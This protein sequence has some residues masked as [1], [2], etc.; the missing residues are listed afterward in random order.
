MNAIEADELNRAAEFFPQDGEGTRP[1]IQV[2]G[3]Q[4]YVYIDDSGT[5]RV[6][7]HLD[8]TENAVLDARGLVPIRF[9]IVVEGTTIYSSEQDSG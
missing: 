8:A 5:V 4:V 6:S 9:R 2:A 3:V 7:V 1:C